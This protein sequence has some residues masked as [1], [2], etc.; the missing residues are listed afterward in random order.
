M[1]LCGH[2]AAVGINSAA[3]PLA[4]DI[5]MFVCHGHDSAR[6]RFIVRMDMALNQALYDENKGK[7]GWV[8]QLGYAM[9]SIPAGAVLL[10]FITESQ[11]EE[12]ALLT[13]VMLPTQSSSGLGQGKACRAC[14]V[15]KLTDSRDGPLQNLSMTAP[16][17]IQPSGSCSTPFQRTTWAT[18]RS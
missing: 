12:Q 5:Y 14:S 8:E 7:D 3:P 9:L 18:P 15:D 11:I 13:V 2:S 6:E 10:R 4:E 16:Q 17:G 1:S